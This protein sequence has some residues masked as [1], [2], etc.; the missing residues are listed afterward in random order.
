MNAKKYLHN[1]MN[2]WDTVFDP[3]TEK[4]EYTEEQL[5]RFAELWYEIKNNKKLT[6]LIVLWVLDKLIILGMFL[7]FNN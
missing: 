2:E 6:L 3:A 5:I 4:C 1:K 7:F